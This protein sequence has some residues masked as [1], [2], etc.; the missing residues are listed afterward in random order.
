MT[1]SNTTSI[2]KSLFVNRANAI[3]A[4]IVKN[5]EAILC[6]CAE[7][8]DVIENE[9]NITRMEKKDDN[10]K[11]GTD[12]IREAILAHGTYA[13]LYD[14]IGKPTGKK[15]ICKPTMSGRMRKIR[16]GMLFLA[17]ENNADKFRTWTESK[18]AKKSGVVDFANI[19]T[20][21]DPK[22][23]SAP[24]PKPKPAPTPAGEGEG[25]GEGIESPE[26]RSKA[27]F[28]AW[29]YNQAKIEF[30]M[31]ALDFAEFMESDKGRKVAD[32]FIEAA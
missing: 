3:S 7:L 11:A 30:G 20:A 2:V 26:K 31:D 10:A 23:A 24:A 21:I 27:E 8:Y 4:D 6:E 9:H 29:V 22:P 18:D 25:E 32:D 15:G 14:S 17:D 12:D 28:L 1:N 16:E 13:W 5:S 19:K